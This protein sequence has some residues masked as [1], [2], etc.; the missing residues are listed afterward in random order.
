MLTEK[1]RLLLA[2]ELSNTLFGANKRHRIRKILHPRFGEFAK[3]FPRIYR[4]C[5]FEPGLLADES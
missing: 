1:D 2:F 5:D 3:K 4:N